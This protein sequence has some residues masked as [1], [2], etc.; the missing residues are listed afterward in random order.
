M[1]MTR[2]TAAIIA[3]T[4][5]LMSTT[6]SAQASLF[7]TF[8]SGSD[9][10]TAEG[11]NDTIAF[12]FAGDEFVGT[13]YNGASCC[14]DLQLYSTN[15]SGGNVQTFG[16]AIPG[17]F[18]GE[19]VVAASLGQGGFPTANIYAG[20]GTEIYGFSHDGSTQTH[21]LSL[22]PGTG[23]VRQI[24]FDPGSSFGGNM[25]ITTSAGYVFEAD[26]NGVLTPL[27]NLGV[28]LEG[29]DIATANWGVHAGDLLVGSETTQS[30]YFI[31]QLAG[32]AVTPV[33]GIVIPVLETVNF[34]PLS[35]SGNPLEGLYVANYPIDIQMAAASQ[36]LPY[37]GD[38][39]LS[40]ESSSNSAF[41]AL[42][43]NLT[44]IPIGNLSGQSED[45]FFITTQKVGE[46]V[47]EPS[48]LALIGITLLSLL[49]LGM[50]RR[51]SD[52]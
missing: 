9:I 38:V 37:L 4:L 3:G 8:V 46:L 48:T 45:G 13:V 28:D 11:V 42:T 47:P 12:T 19:V 41:Y 21:F 10:N 6:G 50:A 23:I 17:S 14:R 44:L 27:A 36:F 33:P 2:T 39:I 32:H 34:V 15:T 30:L 5:G 31:S 26:K 7:S 49:G 29:M 35:F 52:V 24:L 1:S 25:L 40:S 20:A 16:A 43:P 51:R 18:G 22:P